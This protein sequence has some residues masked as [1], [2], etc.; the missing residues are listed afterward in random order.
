MSQQQEEQPGQ[1]QQQPQIES[2]RTNSARQQQPNMNAE[3]PQGFDA[4]VRFMWDEFSTFHGRQSLPADEVERNA[5][6]LRLSA[7]F[8][9]LVRDLLQRS[10]Q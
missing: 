5:Q 7:Q 3:M 1:Q 2:P 10:R 6:L 8:T 4:A 9:M